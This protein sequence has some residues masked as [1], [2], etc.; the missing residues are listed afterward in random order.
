MD[1]GWRFEE[2]LGPRNGS[3]DGDGDVTEAAADA[4]TRG[5]AAL[6]AQLQTPRPALH[7]AHTH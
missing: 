1:H 2:E 6:A 5:A 7:C 4:F 3:T